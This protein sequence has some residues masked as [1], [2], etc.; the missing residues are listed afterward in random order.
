MEEGRITEEALDVFRSRIGT[1]LRIENIFNELACKDSIRKFADGIGD[2][3]PL[4]TDE[5]YASNTRYGSIVAPPSWLYSVFPSWVLQ[6]L[7]GVHS[8]HLRNDWEFYKP[9]LLG[10]RITPECIFTGFDV[11]LSKF[12]GKMVIEDQEAR[13][14]NQRGELVA[15]AKSRGIRTERLAARQIGLYHDIRLPHP[16]TEEE[17]KKIEDAPLE[18]QIRG[19]DVRYW[20]DV[21]VE[22]QLPS[23]VKG[24]LGLTDQIAFY[25]GA[26]PV[27]MKAHALALRQYQAHPAW[28]F[29]DS[30]TSAL[31]PAFSVHYNREA[32][33][34][35]GL[36][37]PYDVG[38][39]RQSWL[40]Q[41]LTDW[42]GDEGWLKR[43]YAKYRRFVFL[44]DAVW[45]T[46]K[47]TRKYID[48]DGEYCV[49]IRTSAINQREE[50]TM[51]G[52]S[53]II[54]PSRQTESRPLERRLP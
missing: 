16:W 20:E 22:E 6:G 25:I 27:R 28:A 39:Q 40:I 41:L 37:Y 10:D 45:L 51:P 2:S 44:S 29:R 33:N 48:E 53:T 7:P 24:P 15:R 30:Q 52:R 18:E 26:S 38:T 36:P 19:S 8:L 35:A 12:A 1:I 21:K 32:A 17:L 34:A 50:E 31:E 4:W 9:V 3:N 43:N 13:Y 14:H 54:L 11:K 23:L 42:M 47:V 5:S 46:G 49:D